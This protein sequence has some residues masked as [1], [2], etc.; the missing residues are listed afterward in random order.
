MWFCICLLMWGVNKSAKWW[1]WCFVSCT[2]GLWTRG[3]SKGPGA[4][5]CGT[6]CRK[7]GERPQEPPEDIGIVIEGVKVLHG[8]TSVASACALLLGLLYALTLLIPNPFVLLS[9]CS[10]KSSC[11][12]SNT[13]CPPKSKIC[14]ADFKARSNNTHHNWFPFWTQKWPRE[15]QF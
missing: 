12:L 2:S 1:Q 6:V 14:M 10:R 3:H 8:L 15:E 4:S 13:R 11:T 5:H 7:V 9:K